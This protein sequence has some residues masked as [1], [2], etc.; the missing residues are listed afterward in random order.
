MNAMNKT[1]VKTIIKTLLITQPQKH[2]TASQLAKFINAHNYNINTDITAHRIGQI[3]KE[4]NRMGSSYLRNIE[5][6]KMSGNK[7][8]YKLKERR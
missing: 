4:E 1:K 5:T 2:W 8:R 3:I 6:V 7:Y